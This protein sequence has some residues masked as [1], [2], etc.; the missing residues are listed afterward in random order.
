MKIVIFSGKGGTGKSVV[1]SS[2]AL[3]LRENIVLVDADSD[4]PNQHLLFPGKVLR[5]EKLYLTK[6]AVIGKGCKG[7]KGIEKVCRFGAIKTINGKPTVDKG[8]CEG[9]GACVLV[10]PK[11]TA[12]LVPKLT[13]KLIVSQTGNF[14][15]VCARLEPG[16]SGTGKLV[17]KAKEAAE[18]IARQNR[19][20]TTLID[21]PAGIGCPVIAAV[22]G[23]DYALGVVEP[24]QASIANL[25]RALEVVKHFKVPFSIILN[26]EGISKKYEK[27]IKRKFRGKLIAKIPHDK[28][29]PL[30]LAKGVP[31]IKGKGKAAKALRQFVNAVEKGTYKSQAIVGRRHG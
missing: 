31:P 7:A 29:V 14:P 12:K 15:L 21:A 13:G 20:N 30:L 27:E 4:C 24:T 1:A 8:K 3:G 5:R 6:F 18:E 11:G 9:C 26:K 28:E 16:E 10:C 17:F 19:I 2:L 25:E 22:G 23:C